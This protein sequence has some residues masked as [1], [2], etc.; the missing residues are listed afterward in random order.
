MWW[1][2]RFGRVG[3]APQRARIH[4]VRIPREHS[5]VELL[6]RGTVRAD[7]DEIDQITPCLV[8]MAWGTIRIEHAVPGNNRCRI[9]R[10]NLV[11][12]LQPIASRSFVVFCKVG[13]RIIV[14]GV[15]GYH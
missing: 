7:R 5:F 3:C 12:R 4:A 15:T 6:C 10:L 9:E 11:E 13:M 14:N 8:D 2:S 1:A